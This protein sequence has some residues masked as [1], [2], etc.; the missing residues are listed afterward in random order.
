MNS[1]NF[2]IPQESCAKDVGM[3]L[4]GGGSSTLAIKGID[5]KPRA[6][7]KLFDEG[8]PGQERRVANHIGIYIKK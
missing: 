6:V 7:S 2:A 3:S 5:G 8:V 1:K 4:D